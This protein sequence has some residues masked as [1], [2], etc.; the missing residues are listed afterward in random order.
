MAC[1][2][3]RQASNAGNGTSIFLVEAIIC[4]GRPHYRSST[5]NHRRT[6]TARHRRVSTRLGTLFTA[7]CDDCAGSGVAE[8]SHTKTSGKATTSLDK[9]GAVWAKIVFCRLKA[10][11]VD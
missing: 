2:E 3:L 9:A 1:A 10:P 11:F 7:G 6:K 5:V 4:V 8:L